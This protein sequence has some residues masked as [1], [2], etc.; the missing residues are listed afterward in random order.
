MHSSYINLGIPIYFSKFRINNLWDKHSS[1]NTLVEQMYYLQFRNNRMPNGM[2]AVKNRLDML[3]YH[4][5]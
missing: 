2:M 3:M 1:I 5:T 4:N